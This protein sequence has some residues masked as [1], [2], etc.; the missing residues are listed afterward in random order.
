MKKSLK[1]LSLV[2]MTD[3]KSIIVTIF[4]D[5]MLENQR[6]GERRKE[7]QKECSTVRSIWSTSKPN[8]VLFQ[9][10]SSIL[11]PWIIVPSGQITGRRKILI[12]IITWTSFTIARTLIV[13]KMRLRGE[14]RS[15]FVIDGWGANFFLVAVGWRS[16]IASTFIDWFLLLIDECRFN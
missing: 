1:L 8:T 11:E 3:C 15:S 12:L 5:T 10:I 16:N 13:S 14:A 4:S 9:C 7:E 6:E 2:S